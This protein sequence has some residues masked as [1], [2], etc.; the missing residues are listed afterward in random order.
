MKEAD[1]YKVTTSKDIQVYVRHGI[2]ANSFL[3]EN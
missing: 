2:P 3:Q 1:A